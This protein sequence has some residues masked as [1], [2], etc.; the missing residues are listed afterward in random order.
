MTRSSLFCFDIDRGSWERIF[1]SP[2]A[3]E[4]LIRA[5]FDRH[6]LD[7]FEIETL[8]PGTNAVFKAG[9]KVVKI[10][11]PEESG[12]YDIDYFEIEKQAQAHIDNCGVTT[13]KLLFSGVVEDKYLFRYFVMEFIGGQATGE[14][15]KSYSDEQKS[16]FAARILDISGKI[17]VS[18]KRAAI[19]VLS[20]SACLSSERWRWKAS[21]VSFCDER[22]F[23]IQSMS[24]DNPVYVHGDLTADNVI[25]DD[26]GGICL[27]DFEDSLIAPYFYEWPPIVFDL[28]KRDPAMMAAYFGSYRNDAFYER[29]TVEST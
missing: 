29:L 6:G 8:T 20:K 25:I 5:V 11:A 15:V 18:I 2:G 14:K 23:V 10:F 16:D 24:F 17:N 19:P 12:F 7:F 26:N 27:I 4:P 28:F 21:P 3:F 1:Q 13:P 9:D 22:A